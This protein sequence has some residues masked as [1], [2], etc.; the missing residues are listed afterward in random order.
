M[1]ILP[2]L[3]KIF[4][5][6]LY[7]Q[8]LN[9]FANICSKYQCGFWKGHS[10]QHCLLASLEKWRNSIDVE[11]MFYALLRHLF[12]SF[13]CLPDDFLVANFSADGF[14]YNATKFLFDCINKSQTKNHDITM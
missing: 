4:K 3:S 13:H 6:C 14:D 9:F 1:I 7:K 8:I 11:N 12:K 10:A 2:N 5:T